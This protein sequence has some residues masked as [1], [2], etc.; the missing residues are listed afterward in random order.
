[1][2]QE[3]HSVEPVLCSPRSVNYTQDAI[4]TADYGVHSTVFALATVIASTCK[5]ELQNMKTINLTEK[6]SLDWVG[7]G[8]HDSKRVGEANCKSCGLICVS[9]NQSQK[10][11]MGDNKRS[12]S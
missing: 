9:W 10:V 5:P 2:L 7:S 8:V 6:T 4:P 12:K 3:H 11:E 1:V